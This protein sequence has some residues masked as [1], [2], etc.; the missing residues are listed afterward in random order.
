[1][2]RLFMLLY[3]LVGPS[4]AGAAIIVVLTMGMVGLRP[5]LGAALLGFVLGLPVARAI[6]GRL[7]A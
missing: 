6:T 3:A 1:M 2:S 7:T 4:L 5:I